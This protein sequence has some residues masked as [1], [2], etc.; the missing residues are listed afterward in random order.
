[1]E[2]KAVEEA[3]GGREKDPK[4]MHQ[5]SGHHSPHPN[6]PSPPCK[7]SLFFSHACDWR[8]RPH[9]LSCCSTR[10]GRGIKASQRGTPMVVC[11][12]AWYGHGGLLVGVVAMSVS[13]VGLLERSI[14]ADGVNRRRALWSFIAINVRFV[15]R[16]P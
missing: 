8:P 11:M 7:S 16:G 9:T 10:V 14:W 6:T 15:G 4:P 2:S 3:R 1:M 5:V 12:P 13:A